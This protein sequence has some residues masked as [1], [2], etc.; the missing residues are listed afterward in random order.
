MTC[1]DARRTASLAACGAATAPTAPTEDGAARQRDNVTARRPCGTTDRR[2]S[3]AYPGRRRC[4][5]PAPA[6]YNSRSARRCRPCATDAFCRSGWCTTC[7]TT[8][9]RHAITVRTTT[10][11]RPGTRTHVLAR[12]TLHRVRVES[13]DVAVTRDAHRACTASAALSRARLRLATRVAQKHEGR[14]ATE[15]VHHARK[16][17]AVAVSNLRTHTQP[18]DRE[19][20]CTSRVR[21]TTAV[22]HSPQTA[23]Q[24]AA[25]TRHRCSTCN[26]SLAAVTLRRAAA[27][28]TAAQVVKGH[29][30]HASAT[31]RRS[32]VSLAPNRPHG[33][34]SCC[35]VREVHGTVVCPVVTTCSRR[36]YRV[37][38]HAAVVC[39]EAPTPT[40]VLL[41][42]GRRLCSRSSRRRRR[43]R[44]S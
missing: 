39:V 3:T 35:T 30:R 5:A 19:Q 9:Q 38:V 13:A 14:V 25:V 37:G 33:F 40:R 18:C 36:H 23:Y 27:T 22:V 41:C 17:D 16:A 7:G 43:Y 11:S 4:R 12:R 26:G 29:A 8:A 44:S 15:V 1:A 28:A 20:G 32:P 42:E 21:C 24:L 2:D 31:T 6:S 34:H 10:L